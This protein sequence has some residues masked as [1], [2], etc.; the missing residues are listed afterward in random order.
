MAQRAA[1][2]PTVLRLTSTIGAAAPAARGSCSVLLIRLRLVL[3]R[4]VGAEPAAC[5]ADGSSGSRT[6]TLPIRSSGSVSLKPSPSRDILPSATP[7]GRERRS[8]VAGFD[9]S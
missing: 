6:A 5:P 8:S 9:G 4:E 1:G 7:V 2:N 3:K